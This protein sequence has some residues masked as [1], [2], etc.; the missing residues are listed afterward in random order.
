MEM[1][2]NWLLDILNYIDI[3]IYRHS[4]P[5]DQYTSVELLTDNNSY[6]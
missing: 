3:L 6:V 2:L 1:N 5:I 4:V